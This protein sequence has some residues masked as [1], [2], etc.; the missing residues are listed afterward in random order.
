MK[1]GLTPEETERGEDRAWH[2]PLWG[3]L[4][5]VG[6]LGVLIY[7]SWDA[8]GLAVGSFSAE[9]RPGLLSDAE[10]GKQGSAR[11]F[12]RQFHGGVPESELLSWLSE[13]RFTIDRSATRASRRV[14]GLPCN[15]R[16]DVSWTTDDGGRLTSATATVQE[17]G[18][19]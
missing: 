8:I 19:L 16:I 5:V 7:I 13:N 2:I 12:E 10:W 11:L 14:A 17:A 18:C 4:A 6:V 1:S 3:G 9:S 15:E